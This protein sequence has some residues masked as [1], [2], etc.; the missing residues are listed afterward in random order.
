MNDRD[1]EDTRMPDD[2]EEWFTC[3]ICGD[4]FDLSCAHIEIEKRKKGSY[5]KFETLCICYSCGED[6]ADQFSKL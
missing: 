2:E 3:E 1:I 4:D 5:F 6:V